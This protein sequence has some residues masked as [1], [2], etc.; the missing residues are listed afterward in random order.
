M[1]KN[2]KIQVDPKLL[3]WARE[4]A[5]YNKNEVA[6]KLKIPT[7]RYTDWE[8]GNEAIPLGYLKK[9]ANH[10]KRQLAVFLLPVPPP[11]TRKPR[12][13]RNLALSQQGL[14]P[15]IML[16]IRR[17]NKYLNIARELYDEFYWL[18]H[19]QWQDE[20]KRIAPRSRLGDELIQWLRSKLRISITDQMGFRDISDAYRKWRNTVEQ[21]LSLFIFQFDMP[22][23]EIDG[24]CF[25]EG[26]PPYA[27]VINKNI[28]SARKIFTIF[29]EFAHIVRHQSGICQ[30]EIYNDERDFEFECNTFAGKFLIPDNDVKPFSDMQTL[31]TFARKYH[32]SREVY[33]R[34]NLEQKLI[35][36]NLFFTYLKE[37]RETP[38]PLRRKPTG[39]VSPEKLSKSTRGDKF[40][41][42]VINAVCENR[43]DYLSASDALGLGYSYIAT[44]E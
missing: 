6:C 18:D 41:N 29:H 31:T 39:Y 37:I 1:P 22:E 3:I 43:I 24:F 19:Y 30:T 25:A 10:F 5:G 21:E 13:F 26:K 17:T 34:R 9:I 44:H 23:E 27:I 42:T 33:L 40:F 36:S 8:S 12:D 2:L 35:S 38:T 11:K 16:A 28:A 32:V 15:E 7:D 20:I 4:E 14:S